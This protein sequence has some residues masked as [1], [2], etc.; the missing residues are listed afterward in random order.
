MA[1]A[2][3]Y[4]ADR[5]VTLA[6]V[7]EI[8]GVSRLFTN[9]AQT[10]K[11]ITA[12]AA[13]GAHTL[14]SGTLEMPGGITRRID[15]LGFRVEVIGQTIRI[16]D[17]DSA[18]VALFAD[19]DTSAIVTYL[20]ASADRNDT[21]ITVADNSPFPASG[22]IHIGHER[23]TY[24]G[25]GGTTQFTG[26]TRGVGGF[27][28]IAHTHQLGAEG[29]GP[30]VADKPR[31]WKGRGV[32]LYLAVL[33]R[34]GSS[35]TT[36]PSATFTLRANSIA[37]FAG[38]LKGGWTYDGK[39][40]YALDCVSVENRMEHQL[41][42]DQYRA[43]AEGFTLSSNVTWTVKAMESDG[44]GFPLNESVTITIS[45]GSYSIDSL[46]AHINAQL[47]AA[48]LTWDV[49][50]ELV[51]VGG[52]WLVQLRTNVP[53]TAV[54]NTIRVDIVEGSTITGDGGFV[55]KILGL[56]DGSSSWYTVHTATAIAGAFTRDGSY[57]PTKT[58]WD[59]IAH[60]TLVCTDELGTWVNQQTDDLPG[61]GTAH[62]FIMV[63]G[64]ETLWL[65]TYDS[66]SKTFTRKI[67]WTFDGK[68]TIFTSTDAA[69]VVYVG[70]DRT[71]EVKQVWIAEGR[72]SKILLRMLHSTGT[73]SY[74]GTDD[75]VWPLQMGL[76]IP[77]TFIDRNE[78]L[79]L[80][81]GLGAAAKLRLIITEPTPAV[82]EV[83][84]MMRS[85]GF[86]LV[87]SGGKITPVVSTNPTGLAAEWTLDESNSDIDAEGVETA[88]GSEL[89]RNKLTLVYNRDP[90]SGEY[91]NRE[92][93]IHATSASEHE[94]PDPI[95]M[96]AR[97]LYDVP[98]NTGGPLETWRKN[99]AAPF[100]AY[101]SRAIRRYIVTAAP[102][103]MG[104][105]PG[106]IV[107]FT[108]PDVPNQESG[109]YG[110]TDLKCWVESVAFDPRENMFT[111]SLLVPRGK[112]YTMGPSAMLDYS[113]GDVGYDNTTSPGNP[114][115]YCRAHE[116]SLSTEAVDVAAF[117]AVGADPPAVDMYVS[118]IECD[119]AA[120]ATPL[121]WDGL[122]VL[123]ASTASN[124]IQINQALA[125]F[126]TARRYY[127]EYDDYAQTAAATDKETERLLH[128]FIADDADN[129]IG[130]STDAANL[131]SMFLAGSTSDVATGQDL[132]R[133]RPDVADDNGE[134][135]SV[136]KLRDLI[137]N[138]ANLYRYICNSQPIDRNF[139]TARTVTSLTYQFLAG[140]FPV[141]VPPGVTQ[142][143][144]TLWCRMGS[145]GGGSPLATYQITASP[146]P[147]T[148]TVTAMTFPATKNQTTTT[149]DN[150]SGWEE[151]TV[152]INLMP[153]ADGRCWI[154]V[155]GKGAQA[156]DSA[157]LGG[158]QGAF[159]AP[160]V[161]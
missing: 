53:S 42:R 68:P 25:K 67:A 7:L 136:W 128:A 151:T 28:G 1:T 87:W 36:T 70:E 77:A 145:G 111:L 134:P 135:L 148:G 80:D 116:F 146:S 30:E 44:A 83:E 131:W 39:G 84:S 100:A 97:S 63:Q 22:T 65:V 94:Q 152:T 104:I 76:G 115:L 117:D 61:I 105:S 91:H 102:S 32:T 58:L 4:Q 59:P 156:N 20:T 85:R 114:F 72:M 10:A 143:T 106:D 125:G 92:S 3:S 132:F 5:D 38:Y 119:P 159:V 89:I 88:D 121:R 47:R 35:A 71:I 99:V 33:E 82:E 46:I 112:A 78:I 75:D 60:T 17:A 9:V 66:G 95:E 64:E 26:C 149:A 27:G 147:P 133:R 118:V 56:T 103:L 51:N 23:I 45:S 37:Y 69:K 2:Q 123:D 24:S 13:T 150:T 34:F 155:E 160:T 6:W 122:L 43:R 142:I 40:T 139:T 153:A 29:L 57:T 62:G 79:A 113:R 107:E 129:Q 126:D 137:T 50:L 12:W 157:R 154:T 144:L 18:L 158:I 14:C 19:A 138:A 101:F 140:P 73:A 48:A 110:V 161:S 21:T 93:Y 54:G 86:A 31:V 90:A 127:V 41:L 55:L 52:N 74:N 108:H 16:L 96:E 98:G 11:I 120:P 109:A 49:S 130:A 124:Y 81:T 8:E 15:L 141:L